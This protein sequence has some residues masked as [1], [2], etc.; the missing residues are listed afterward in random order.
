MK[1]WGRRGGGK[2]EVRLGLDGILDLES[3]SS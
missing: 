2:V 3:D 1:M